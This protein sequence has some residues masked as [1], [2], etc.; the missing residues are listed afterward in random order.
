ML[1][2]FHLPRIL[3][4]RTGFDLLAEVNA[5]LARGVHNIILDLRDTAFTDS[6]GLGCLVKLQQQITGGGKCLA[7]CSVHG[8]VKMVLEL[9]ELE[10]IFEIYTNFDEYCRL[11]SNP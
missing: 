5:S 2:V 9:T 7:L 8:Q 11:S 10:G 4:H 6:A 3:N 1:E